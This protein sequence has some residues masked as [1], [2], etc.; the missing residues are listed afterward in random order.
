MKL[1]DAIIDVVIFSVA[2]LI[3]LF[4]VSYKSTLGCVT[5]KEMKEILEVKEGQTLAD[6]AKEVMAERNYAV[7]YGFYDDGG[8]LNRIK[9]DADGYVICS[10]EKS[11]ES[12]IHSTEDNKE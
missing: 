5:E 3:V 6:R 10:K 8:V 2:V 4:F 7:C 1:K 11:N 9:V 12:A